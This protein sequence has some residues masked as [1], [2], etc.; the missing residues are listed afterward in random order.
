MPTMTEAMQQVAR[1]VSLRRPDLAAH[2]EIAV[3]LQ[4]DPTLDADGVIAVL[5]EA[6][7][8]H[9]AEEA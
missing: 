2:D 3:V 8:E 7:A 9:N 4:S 6:R 5:D 1:E